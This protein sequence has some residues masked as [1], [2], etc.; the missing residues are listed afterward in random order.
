LF[1]H[2]LPAAKDDNKSLYRAFPSFGLAND[3]LEV[4]AEA[5]VSGENLGQDEICDI[6]CVSFSTNDYVGHRYG[7][8]SP[9]VMDISVRTDRALAKLFNFLARKVPG[10]LGSVVIALSADHAVAPIPE[11]AARYGLNAGRQPSKAV[12]QRVEQALD[13]RFG[14][15]D[16]VLADDPHLYLNL[17]VAAEKMLAVAE[18][19]KVAVAAA[20]AVKGVYCAF[21]RSQILSGALPAWEWTQLVS[22]GF[23]PKLSGDVVL[24][25]DPNWLL[26]DT[27]LGTSHGTPWPYDTHTPLLLSGPGIEPG[28]FSRRVS[29]MDLAPTLCCLL[30]VEFPSGCL[31][32]PL[33]EAL[34][35]HGKP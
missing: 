17:K 22:H 9:E 33:S 23:H 21:S 7:P 29:T 6:L 4:S 35:R 5:A 25:L 28:A 26:G 11:E 24:I 15:A 32:T 27:P 19:E 14:D 8:N 1:S 30:G 12:R 10:G 31:G 13:E 2:K 16:W 3:Y 20:D 34:D 18:V